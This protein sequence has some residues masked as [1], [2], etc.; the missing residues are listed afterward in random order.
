MSNFASLEREALAVRNGLQRLLIMHY[1]HPDFM[2][3]LKRIHLLASATFRREELWMRNSGH[4]YKDVHRNHHLIIEFEFVA[5]ET[6]AKLE[7][8]GFNVHLL[9]EKL[10]ECLDGHFAYHDGLLVRHLESHADEK[11]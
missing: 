6:A 7:N 4:I 10:D 2:V 5:V 9:L 1:L 11:V 8:N 3:E